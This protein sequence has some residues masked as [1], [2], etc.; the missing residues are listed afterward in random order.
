MCEVSFCSWTFLQTI[1]WPLLCLT[2]TSCSV[3]HTVLY[4]QRSWWNSNTHKVFMWFWGWTAFAKLL[5][6]LF[7]N[8]INKWKG[9]H[10]GFP[11]LFLLSS[12]P[13][14]L[15]SD[16][17]SG[18]SSNMPTFHHDKRNGVICSLPH[19]SL[20]LPLDMLNRDKSASF[21]SQYLSDLVCT[22]SSWKSIHNH[23]K[24]AAWKQSGWT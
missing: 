19:T 11:P 1:L 4:L 17:I 23:S 12:F 7:K 15:P 8:Q 10:R 9:C 18:F 13:H 5:F 22:V 24:L 20:I 2:C 3:T 16:L 6:K 21:Q 14:F